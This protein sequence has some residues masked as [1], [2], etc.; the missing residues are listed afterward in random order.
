M[1]RKRAT[2]PNLGGR[3][4]IFPGGRQRC[5]NLSDDA[6]A[7]AEADAEVL[8]TTAGIRVSISQT[9]EAAVRAFNAKQFKSRFPKESSV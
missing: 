7:K 2:K 8:S 5:L 9:I 6:Y 1:T 4:S 3:P